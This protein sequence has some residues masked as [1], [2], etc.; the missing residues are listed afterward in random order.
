[1]YWKLPFFEVNLCQRVFLGSSP[2][3]Q[4]KK[5]CGLLERVVRVGCPSCR[6]ANGD[7][8]LKEILSTS[9][10]FPHS[11]IIQNRTPHGKGCCSLYATNTS[12]RTGVRSFCDISYHSLKGKRKYPWEYA[13]SLKSVTHGHCDDRPTVTYLAIG[14]YHP[15][16]G[17]KLYYLVT[18]YGEF[19]HHH[20]HHHHVACPMSMSMSINYF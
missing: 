11:W 3:V 2:P 10:T 12:C 13:L 6:Q 1:M 9:L 5:F 8:A 16:T 7:K 15:A 20:H 19:G 18:D 17:I 4:D 14:N